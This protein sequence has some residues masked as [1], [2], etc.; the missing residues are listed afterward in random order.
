MVIHL[1]K[2]MQYVK[3]KTDNF[4]SALLYLKNLIIIFEHQQKIRR[5]LR[6]FSK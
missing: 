4:H 1:Y 3:K 2:N 5:E 6:Y